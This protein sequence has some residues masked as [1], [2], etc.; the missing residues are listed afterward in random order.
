MGNIRMFLDNLNRTP[1]LARLSLALDGGELGIWVW[2]L[3]AN[4]VQV[5]RRWCEMIG[6]DHASTPMTLETWSAWVHPEVQR[7][8]SRDGGSLQIVDGAARTTFA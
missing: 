3:R 6:L 8:A 5:D 4:S 1:L 2:A 7:L